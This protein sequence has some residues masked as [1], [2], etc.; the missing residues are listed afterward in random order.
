VGGVPWLALGEK[1][2]IRYDGR[3]E[4]HHRSTTGNPL[5]AETSQGSDRLGSYQQ[6]SSTLSMGQP[7]NTKKWK[8]SFRSYPE[9]K[10]PSTLFF[11]QSF[12]VALN[13][14]AYH[15]D[16]DS[17]TTPREAAENGVSSFFPSFHIVHDKSTMG[18]IELYGQM[19][20]QQS[21]KMGPVAK[22]LKQRNALHS[23]PVA[24]FTH[25]CVLIM[26]T[27]SSFMSTS[28]LYRKDLKE[29]G[30]G[31]TGSVTHIPKGHQ[32]DVI[33]SSSP[34]IHPDGIRQAFR[35]WGATLQ[36][37]YNTQRS[38]AVK[39]D[40]TLPYLQYNT[41]NGAFY[42][43][44][45]EPNKNY[46]QTIL[47]VKAQAESEQLPFRSWLA[48]SWWYYKGKGGGV[49][50][51]V[52]RPDIF[53]DGLDYVR[54]VTGWDIV[55]HNRYWAPDTVYAKQNGGDYDFVIEDHNAKALPLEE[56]FWQDL[57][58][59]SK[60]WG[61]TVYEQDWLDVQLENTDYLLQNIT[62]GETWLLQMG[63]AAQD[64][65][66]PI[67]YCMAYPRHILQSLQID[68]VT[69]ARASDDYRPS[70]GRQNW[71]IGISSMFVNALDI[72]PLKDNFWSSSER[73]N[74]TYPTG[75]REEA[76]QLHAVIST[77][78][79]GIVSPSDS[80]QHLNSSLLMKSCAQ[81][82]RLLQP[83]LPAV[84]T[85]A[86]IFH[87]AGM[88]KFSEQSGSSHATKEAEAYIRGGNNLKAARMLEDDGN[89]VHDM[90]NRHHVWTTKTELSGYTYTYVLA[91]ESPAFILAEDDLY[92]SLAESDGFVAWELGINDDGSLPT[93]LSLAVQVPESSETNIHVYAVAP[94]FSN[95]FSF[96]GEAVTKWTPVSKARFSKLVVQSRSFTINVHGAPTE[97]VWLVVRTPE[98]KLVKVECTIP[99]SGSAR[100]SS[101]SMSCARDHNMV[102]LA[103]SVAQFGL[104][105]FALRTYP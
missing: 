52:A 93:L 94:I 58:R 1:A 74:H 37:R 78:S 69:Q 8:V 71:D 49:S 47:D 23:G 81:D 38:T 11:S 41:D 77:Y 14:T 89:T 67:Q 33:L 92:P 85:D 40:T 36:K 82:G 2:C 98:E 63:R 39:L 51:W 42:Y 6:R 79:T 96:L 21:Y 95:G 5:F 54:N 76:P 59:S 4:C 75:D 48:D 90:S 34:R 105:R 101:H 25:Q 80:L 46:Q 84:A 99:S 3:E 29:Y 72:V 19:A 30:F 26:S 97:V 16:T 20:G 73:Q 68:Y 45:T 53:P 62:A 64:N 91:I 87:A 86:A 7:D 24:I 9:E 50:R 88:N 56:R 27:A 66:V 103:E 35:R 61:M 12:P 15:N 13:D 104:E 31:V 28:A 32:L 60:K 83:D 65:G 100:F 22:L 57:F 18:Y 102:L 55:A 44:V 70:L 43:Y 10:V 17:V